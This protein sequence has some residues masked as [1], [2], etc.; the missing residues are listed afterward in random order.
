VAAVNPFGADRILALTQQIQVTSK[1]AII[2]TTRRL[3]EENQANIRSL[4]GA[5]A[6]YLRLVDGSSVKPL[7]QVRPDGMT[8]T[9]FDLLN[10]VVDECYRALVAASPFGPEKGGHYR[11]DHWLFVNGV[12]HDPDVAG[13]LLIGPG[14]KV[15]I[16]N[17]RP[18][19]RKIEGGAKSRF[20]ARLTDRRPGLSVQAPN[21]VYEIT[22]RALQSRFGNIARIR[23]GYHAVAGKDARGRYP[24]LEIEAA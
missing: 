10:H 22:A 6:S 19:A 2:D 8:V 5:T 15:V 11:D 13:A 14:D 16:V 3:T 18:Y 21:G 20:R 24:A 23:F 9:R 4:T 1:Q 7:E 12:R 17:V